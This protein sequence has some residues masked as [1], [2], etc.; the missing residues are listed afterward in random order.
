MGN[1]W[2]KSQKIV[3]FPLRNFDPTEYLASVPRQTIHLHRA[4]LEGVDLATYM[5]QLGDKDNIFLEIL[6]E[7]KVF[8]NFDVY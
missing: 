1:K 5:S 2:I 4:E 7:N 6:P 3:D 8:Y